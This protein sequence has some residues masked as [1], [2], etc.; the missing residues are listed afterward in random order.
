MTLFSQPTGANEAGGTD[1][2][3]PSRTARR[4]L[5]HLPRDPEQ[6]FLAEEH[7]NGFALAML[8]EE[9][10]S[11]RHRLDVGPAEHGFEAIGLTPAAQIEGVGLSQVAPP[12]RT[13]AA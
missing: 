12:P 10:A 5:V 8:R 11:G 3:R 2:R 1:E 13:T 7:F 6:E 4:P 9:V